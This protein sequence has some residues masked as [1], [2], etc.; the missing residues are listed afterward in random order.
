MMLTANVEYKFKASHWIPDH[1][2]CGELHE[3]EWTVRV[4]VVRKPGYKPLHEGMIIDFQNLYGWVE[5]AVESAGNLLNDVCPVPT[6]ENFLGGW[7][8]QM[9]KKAL[10]EEIEV[11]KVQ[12]WENQKYFCEW[13]K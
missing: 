6:C 12:L 3:H 4:G 10:P 2:T 1:P 7:L 5:W 11:V 9:L 8:L 13:V